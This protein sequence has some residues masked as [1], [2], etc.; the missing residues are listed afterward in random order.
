MTNHNSK[1][2]RNI[3]DNSANNDRNSKEQGH[4]TKRNKD[5]HKKSLLS[6]AFDTTEQWSTEIVSI[7]QA[8]EK[9]RS[10]VD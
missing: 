1:N 8:L 7:R 9:R 5:T 10:N 3:T 4:Q 6:I 2:K